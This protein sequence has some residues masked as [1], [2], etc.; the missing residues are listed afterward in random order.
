MRDATHLSYYV[1][2]RANILNPSLLF[3]AHDRSSSSSSHVHGTDGKRR[4]SFAMH[5][6]KPRLAF[7]PMIEPNERVASSRGHG[8]KRGAREVVDSD[9]VANELYETRGS[10]KRLPSMSNLAVAESEGMSFLSGSNFDV[11][12]D[13]AWS[14]FCRFG[15]LE[16]VDMARILELFRCDYQLNL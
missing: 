12:T 13:L 9:N 5:E 3:Q 10:S 1:P 2:T 7:A 8:V 14:S 16:C 11:P 4:R 6:M 15:R